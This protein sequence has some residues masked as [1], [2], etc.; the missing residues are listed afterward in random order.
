[1]ALP[2]VRREARSRHGD[3]VGGVAVEAKSI[4]CIVE[5]PRTFAIGLD[6]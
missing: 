2:R 1:M 3:R 5:F 6:A 4:S